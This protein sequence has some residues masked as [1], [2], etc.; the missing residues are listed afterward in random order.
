MPSKSGTMAQS[1]TLVDWRTINVSLA[2]NEKPYS[3]GISGLNLVNGN[4]EYVVYRIYLV[5]DNSWTNYATLG[6]I[7]IQALSSATVN[8]TYTIPTGDRNKF[9]GKAL[10]LRAWVTT[11]GNGTA[12]TSRVTLASSS[13]ITVNYYKGVTAGEKIYKTDLSQIA[14]PDD[15]T[16]IK[17]RTKY[18]AGASCSASDFN[19]NVLGI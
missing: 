2:S 1:G 9:K 17:Y 10:Y 19:T 8:G 5:V 12:R 6:D 11:D 7:P 15:A 16:Y 3:V 13:T 18:S 14:T 4:N